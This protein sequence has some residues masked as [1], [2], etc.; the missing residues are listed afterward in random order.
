MPIEARV[1]RF[2]ERF[3]T[4]VDKNGPVPEYDHSLGECWIWNGPTT[5]LG[6]VKCVAVAGFTQ[7]PHRAS[8]ILANGSIPSGLDIDHLCRV[9]ACV[10][11]NHLEAV[12]HR[13]NI[14]RGVS[15]TAI[16]ARKTHC[17]Q[18]HPYS[19]DNLRINTDGG[20]K[21]LICHNAKSRRWKL[22]QRAKVSHV[23]E[24]Q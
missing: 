9:P 1:T 5:K 22:K 10:R 14:L 18:G 15:P 24:T 19:G 17:P 20:R 21:C 11:P 12:T 4:L 8:Y 23:R 6:Y 13:E 16:N 3:W 2:W 7:Q